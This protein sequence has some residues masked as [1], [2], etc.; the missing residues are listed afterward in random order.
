MVNTE[1]RFIKIAE[2]DYFIYNNFT[3]FYLDLKAGS[4]VKIRIRNILVWAGG[5][6]SDRLDTAQIPS[7]QGAQSYR[8]WGNLHR[9]PF[10]I[11]L[12]YP[13][14]GKIDSTITIVSQG[15]GGQQC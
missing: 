1:Y 9:I 15:W 4:G 8:I 13:W 10:I 3:L 12:R 11:L 14:I 5:N 2:N 7:L 6:I